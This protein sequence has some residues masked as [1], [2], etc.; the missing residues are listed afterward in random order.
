MKPPRPKAGGKGNSRTAG[1]LW[2]FTSMASPTVA[3]AIV[4]AAV[5]IVGAPAG[6]EVSVV[7]PS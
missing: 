1:L 2:V 5:S 4:Y 7:P 6:G 3:I